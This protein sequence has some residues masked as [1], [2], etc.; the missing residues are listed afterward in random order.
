MNAKIAKQDIQEQQTSFPPSK[1]SE[2]YIG[3][4]I[5]I[6]LFSA[7]T[8]LTELAD[9]NFNEAKAKQGE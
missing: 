5:N 6:A 9:Q 1:G 2:A 3:G 8:Q 4:S 7:V